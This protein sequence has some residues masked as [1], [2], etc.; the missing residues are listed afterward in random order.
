M[1]V[2]YAGD[3]GPNLAPDHRFPHAKYPLLHARLRTLYPDLSIQTVP[4]APLE[5]LALVHDASYLEAILGSGKTG[6][7]EVAGLW[8]EI[9]FPESPAI[10]ARARRSV[11]A[12]VH[13]ALTVVQA[14]PG[15]M[16]V[17][18]NMAG[19]THHAGPA[20]GGGFCLFNDVAVAIRVLQRDARAVGRPALRAA[21]IDLD[22][23]QG[24]GTAEIFQQDPTVFTLSMHGEKNYPFRKAR[25][26]LDIGL[27]DGCEDACYLDALHQALAELDKRFD[28]DLVVYL[29][30]ADIHAGDRLGR[31]DVSLAGV[32]RRDHA[33]FDWCWARRLPVV[34][35]MGG[36]Y[37]RVIDDTV[38]VQTQTF[39]IA[40]MYASRWCAGLPMEDWQNP[41]HE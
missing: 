18:A 14:Q 21:V 15:Q 23:H 7:P 13:A 33:V 32:G 9:G 10:V 5:D 30:G 16:R 19:G 36:G 37:G 35:V 39:G 11:A 26:S 41:P 24:N 25:S 38:A 22:V 28:A 8:R 1:N 2:F 4:E 3:L 34:M 27:P 31:L 20:H 6:A 40:R 29:A 17:A 12:T